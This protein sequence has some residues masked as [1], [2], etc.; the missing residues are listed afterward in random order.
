M[1]NPLN[2]ISSVL[3]ATAIG[4]CV[5]NESGL[6]VDANTRYCDYYGLTHSDVIDKPFTDHLPTNIR[7]KTKALHDEFIRTG[8]GQT[9][10]WDVFNMQGESLIL[11]TT[12][13]LLEHPDGS[14]WIV[15]TVTDITKERQASRELQLL[16]NNTAESYVLMDK[17]LQILSFN[18]KFKRLYQQFFNKTVTRGDSILDY[19]QPERVPMLKT[20]YDAVL[21]GAIETSDITVPIQSGQTRTYHL[22]YAPATDHSGDIVG[23]FVTANDITESKQQRDLL[24]N[25]ER[26]YRSLVEHGSDA[27]VI[28][29]AEGNT[30]YASPSVEQVLGYRDE[31]LKAMNLFEAM[32]PD[33]AE[34]ARNKMSEVMNLPGVPVKGLTAR[35]RHRDGSWRWMEATVTNLL[36]DPAI[37]GIV[38]HFRDVTEYY[39]NEREVNLMAELSRMF[40]PNKNLNDILSTVVERVK[41][42][43]EFKLAEIWLLDS[44]KTTLSMMANVQTSPDL[45]TFYEETKRFSQATLAKGLPGIT[46]EA[47]SVMSWSVS[48]TESNFIRAKEAKKAGIVSAYGIP[49]IYQQEVIG[50]VLLGL[51]TSNIHDRKYKSLF[52]RISRYLGIEIRR[53]QLEIELNQLFN[54]IPDVICIAS[55][56]GHLTKVNPA[57]CRLLKYTE[58]EL[59]QAPFKDLIHKDDLETCLNEL[60]KLTVKSPTCHFESRFI[61]KKGDVLW[62]LWT[63]TLAPEHGLVF[64]T[65]RDITDKKLDEVRIR[66]SNERFERVTLATNDAIWDWDIRNNTLFWGHAYQTI[67][68]HPVKRDEVL[69]LDAWTSNVHP[70]DFDRVLASLNAALDNPN[71]TVYTS[72]YRFQKANGTYANVVDRGYILRDDSGSAVRIVGALSDITERISH[73]TAIEHQNERLR[74][75]AW[76]QS[77]VVRAPLA[78]LIGFSNMLIS[79]D[80]HAEEGQQ[81]VEHIRASAIELDG[82]IRDIAA[83]SDLFTLE[84]K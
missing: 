33:D 73:I 82:I 22:T 52:D 56:D 15:T 6:I 3:N 65:A 1:S 69:S 49:L 47:R 20:L 14:R 8:T 40:R 84:S 44:Q 79:K 60:A 70:D 5:T 36:H 29:D 75:I 74:E 37:N 24:E 9:S 50:V 17:R 46:W 77:H 53:K 21:A 64:V 28:I 43:D 66:E 58:E 13:T 68:G 57:M 7:N 80:Y 51:T 27:V 12:P 78:R 26:R 19:A 23:V 16:I 18:N 38:D 72:E 31:E 34:G 32:H 71:E 55:L 30:T 63:S 11:S 45:K 59:L 35:I 83:K 4:V 42:Y 62:A 10:E 81:F 39:T 54:I 61:T 41:V 76:I 2:L 25:N 48:Q 67:F